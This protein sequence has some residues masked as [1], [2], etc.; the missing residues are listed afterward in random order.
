MK[1][2]LCTLLALIMLMTCAFA[3]GIVENPDA[4]AFQ[5]GF[6]INSDA[7]TGTVYFTPMI[8]PDETYSFPATNNIIFAPGA[9]SSW[10]T[11]GGMV[12]LGTGDVG[13]YQA[14]GEPVQVLHPGDVALCPP[15]VKHWHGGSTDTQ[16]AHIAINTNPDK[17]G[18]EWFDCISEEE[19]A[20]LSTE[21]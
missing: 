6:E 19:Y 1:R 4:L 21:R 18:L 16:F 2:L 10:H 8:Q 13:Y 5:R 15:G 7:F 11:H 3:E 20:R 14:E 12:I 17:T 9:R